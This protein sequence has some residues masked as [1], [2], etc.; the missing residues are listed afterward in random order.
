MAWIAGQRVVLR[1][2]ERDDI[3]TRWESEQTADPTEARLRH[4][5][6]PPRSLQQRE[7]EFDAD[8]AEPDPATLSLVIEAEGRAIGDVN[9]L[10]IDTR[11]R[12][13]EVGLSIWRPEDWG[14]GFGSDALAALLRWGFRQ[15]NLHRVELAVDPANDRAMHVY[16][17]LG[18]LLE[19]TRRE[20]HFDDGAYHDELVMG[21][22]AR[23]FEARD[24]ITAEERQPARARPAQHAKA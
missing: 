3:R 22:L 12:N 18:F 6:E 17:K 23:E 1:A 24:T 15:L 8:Q 16:E 21:L 10:H 5:H 7:T 2:W 20:S 13:A 11:N 19:G 9:L 14:R 4:W